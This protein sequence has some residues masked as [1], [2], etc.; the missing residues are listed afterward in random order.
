MMS[1]RDDV[2]GALNIEPDGGFAAEEGK[3]RRRSPNKIN[4]LAGTAFYESTSSYLLFWVE[5][6]IEIPAKF[7]TGSFRKLSFLKKMH[8]FNDFFA[9]FAAKFAQ[10]G[11]NVIN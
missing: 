2:H 4:L 9:T 1:S 11:I 7:T 3:G 8:F 5:C 10:I 6:S